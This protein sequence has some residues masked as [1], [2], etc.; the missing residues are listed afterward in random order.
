MRRI[1]I[2]FQGEESYYFHLFFN[3]N[4]IDKENYMTILLQ[5]YTRTEIAKRTAKTSHKLVS[6]S[7]CIKYNVSSYYFI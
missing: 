2:L 6:L 7:I 1:S 3:N 5:L 4:S